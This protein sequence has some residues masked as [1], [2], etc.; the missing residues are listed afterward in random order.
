MEQ[1]PVREPGLARVEQVQLEVRELQVQL[2]QWEVQEPQVQLEQREA[3][4]QQVLLE[5][6]AREQ[7]V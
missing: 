7:Q 5:L 1:E 6:V 3:R 2:E 4:E